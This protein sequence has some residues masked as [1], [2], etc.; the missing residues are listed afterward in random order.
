MK[1]IT[2]RDIDKFTD[3][4][5]PKPSKTNKKKIESIVTD[6]RKNGDNAVKKYEKKFGGFKNGPMK[7]S[8]REILA[9]YS[10]VTK[11]QVNA[12]KIAKKRLSKTELAIKK[13][14]GNF[15][16]T[17]DGVKIKKFFLPISSVGC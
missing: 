12:I 3:S 17:T 6:V 5:I 4:I 11:D 15:E 2:V 10:K 1:I 7:V 13:R 14:L 9:S 16:V 8:K